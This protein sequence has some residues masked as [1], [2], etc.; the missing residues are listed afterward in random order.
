MSLVLI[1]FFLLNLGFNFLVLW[2]GIWCCLQFLLLC[3]V[4]PGFV[5]S[6]QLCTTLQVWSLYSWACFWFSPLIEF[7]HFIFRP[8]GSI[9]NHLQGQSGSMIFFYFCFN[10][11][12]QK[13]LVIVYSP[14]LS[15]L[16]KGRN[17]ERG[18]HWEKTLKKQTYQSDLEGKSTS[19]SSP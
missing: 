18:E 15:S 6:H 2:N 14:L 17:L 5:C 10:S 7:W 12:Q 11:R 3:F 16:F 8:N 19:S 4:Q 1:L 9:S 13:M